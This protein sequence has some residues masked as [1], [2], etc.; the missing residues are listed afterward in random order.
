MVLHK[1][2]PITIVHINTAYSKNNAPRASDCRRP[3]PPPCCS[4]GAPPRA[5]H[6]QRRQTVAAQG[7]FRFFLSSKTNALPA[8][9]YMPIKL[10]DKNWRSH[11]LRY[12]FKRAEE[13]CDRSRSCVSPSVVQVVPQVVGTGLVYG[14][15]AFVLYIENLRSAIWRGWSCWAAR[16]VCAMC[17]D[18]ADCNRWRV[19]NRW[20]D[21]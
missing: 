17:R 18:S 20:S 12:G 8:V 19:V 2:Q 3:P 6:M 14:G 7:R 9:F 1:R 16:I 15:C 21:L 4:L 5:P 11:S 10:K 13:R